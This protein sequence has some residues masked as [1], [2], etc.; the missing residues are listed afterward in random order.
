MWFVETRELSQ[1]VGS[2]LD[3]LYA[4]L[5]EPCLVLSIDDVI[6]ELLVVGV[7]AELLVEDVEV[8]AFP[9]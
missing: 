9:H 5:D 1:V 4:L 2:V 8:I 3:P 7:I 6:P